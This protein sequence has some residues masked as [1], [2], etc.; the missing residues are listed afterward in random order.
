MKNTREFQSL[1]TEFHTAFNAPVADSPQLIPAERAAL[2]AALIQEELDEY[3]EAIAEADVVG[4][5]DALGD[6]LY[7]VLGAA[8]EHGIQLRP[9]FEEIHASNMSKLGTDGTPI[10][11]EDGKV[12]KGPDYFK[13]NLDA[14]IAAQNN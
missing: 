10:L 9:V 11:R 6:L 8:I 12:L 1:V 14:I 7:V 2:R 13:P 5:A 3:K 4:V